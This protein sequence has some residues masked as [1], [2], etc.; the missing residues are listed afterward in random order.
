MTNLFDNVAGK[1]AGDIDDA[2]SKGQYVR[3]ELFV[4]LAEKVIPPAGHLLD[5]GCG[6]GRL[7]FMLA[8]SGFRVRAV[9]T[10]AGMIEQARSVDTKG[11]QIEFD[12][13]ESFDQALPANTFDAIVCSSVIEYVADADE[14]LQ[15]FRRALR[16]PGVLVISYANASSYFRKRWAREADDN[17]MGPSQH[18][19]WDWPGFRSLLEKNGFETTTLPKFYESPWDSRPWGPWF[20][21]SAM[22]GSLG[23]VAARAVST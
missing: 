7:S 17:P 1:F 11:L 14:L 2:M 10:S 13:I 4:A 6:P 19:V 8:R 3:G 9:D 16:K 23:V 21:G 15:G 5:Y 18:H 12:Q 20:R 22:V